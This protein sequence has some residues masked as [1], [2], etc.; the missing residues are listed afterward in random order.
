[1]N[2]YLDFEAT[3]FAENVIAIGASCIYGSFDCLVKTPKNDKITNFIT[4]LTGITKEMSKNALSTEEAFYDF[5]LWICEMGKC[6]NHQTP[7][8]F[9][10]YGKTDKIFVKNA[11]KHIENPYLIEFVKNLSESLIDDSTEVCRFFHIK[12]I[13][14]HKAIK[15]FFPN[16]ANQDHDPLNDAILLQKLM[17]QISISA[18]LTKCPFSI[19][20]KEKKSTEVKKNKKL[21]IVLRSTCPATRKRK[22]LS[23]DS[24]EEA[25]DWAIAKI[26][27]TCPNASIQNIKSRVKKAITKQ[28]NYVGYQWRVE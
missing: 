20:T 22:I 24:A 28:G 13:G 21:S 9:H 10:T 15:Y 27:S 11:I 16:I 4:E 2:I 17:E 3:Q 12:A 14:V 1:M 19:I 6:E 5:Y 7:I 26:Q 25:I 23:F 18:E 8:F